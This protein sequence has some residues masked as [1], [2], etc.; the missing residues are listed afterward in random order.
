[1][2]RTDYARPLALLLFP[3]LFGFA[4]AFIF[5][6]EKFLK[7]PLEM[8]SP[9]FACRFFPPN[10]NFW[11]FFCRFVERPPVSPLV[12]LR[13]LLSDLKSSMAMSKRSSSSVAAEVSAFRSVWA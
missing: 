2:N 12:R 5:F 8:A 1:M 11:S 4:P 13:F 9:L 10:P 7:S 6:A 3:G